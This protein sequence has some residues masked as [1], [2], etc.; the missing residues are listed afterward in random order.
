MVQSPTPGERLQLALGVLAGTPTSL[1]ALCDGGGVVPIDIVGHDREML[2]VMLPKSATTPG[3]GLRLRLR[4]PRGSGYDLS[5]SVA[6]AFYHSEQL[7]TA[8]LLVERVRR[9]NGQ[10][11]GPRARLQDQALVGVIYSSGLPE[12][13]EFDVH[14]VDLSPDGIAFVTDADLRPGDLL[15]IMATVDRKLVRMRVRV[16]HVTT[17]HYGRARVGCEVTSIDGSERARLAM[18]AAL[19]DDGGRQTDRTSDAAAAA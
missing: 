14:V 7:S 11:S 6:R 4:T 16:L 9:V 5:L 17:A 1:E 19:H 15:S 10:R 12:R 8:H 3:M 2:H 13:S 18:V